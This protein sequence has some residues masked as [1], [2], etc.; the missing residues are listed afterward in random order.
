MARTKSIINDKGERV[1][2]PMTAEE[3]IEMDRT[4]AEIEANDKI[5]KAKQAARQSALHKLIEL[6]LTEEEIAAL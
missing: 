6:G 1:T 5:R 4:A 2:L 3:E